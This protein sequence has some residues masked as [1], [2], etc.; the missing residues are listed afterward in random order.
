V[1]LGIRNAGD[2][3]HI[4]EEVELDVALAVL[5]ADELPQVAALDM[6]ST[7]FGEMKLIKHN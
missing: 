3:D 7:H 2:D 1:F 6:L 4:V 5:A